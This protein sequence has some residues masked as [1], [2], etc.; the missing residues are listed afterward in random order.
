MRQGEVAPQGKW[1]GSALGGV[2]APQP[3]SALYSNRFA[4]TV[5]LTA[6]EWGAVKASVKDY[7]L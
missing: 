3:T 5:T 1:T 4:G 6:A 2:K 7:M